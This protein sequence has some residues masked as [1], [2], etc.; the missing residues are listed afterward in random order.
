M[1]N[2]AK[3]DEKNDK[4]QKKKRVPKKRYTLNFN[5]I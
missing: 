4:K 3:F 5:F 1:L 2:H